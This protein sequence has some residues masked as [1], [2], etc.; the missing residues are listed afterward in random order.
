MDFDDGLLALLNGNATALLSATQ[1]SPREVR[2]TRRFRLGL[3][4]L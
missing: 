3:R 2:L 1:A 4:L